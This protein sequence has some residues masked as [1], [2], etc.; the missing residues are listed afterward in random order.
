MAVTKSRPSK[1]TPPTIKL[2]TSAIQSFGGMAGSPTQKPLGKGADPAFAFKPYQTPKEAPFG[3]YDPQLFTQGQT[4]GANL[5]FADADTGLANVRAQEDLWHALGQAA[6]QHDWT[7]SDLSLQDARNRQN[8]ETQTQDLTRQYDRLGTSQTQ[9]ANAAGVGSGGALVAAA[10]A[11]QGNQALDQS[12]LQTAFDRESQDVA[13]RKMRENQAYNQGLADLQT[14]YQRGYS[15]RTT[16]Q[17]RRDWMYATIYQPGLTR[18]EVSNAQ[19]AGML[20]TPPVNEH[21]NPDTG[22]GDYRTVVNTHKGIVYHVHPNGQKIVVRHV[23]PTAPPPTP[24]PK[25]K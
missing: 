24:K 19:Q 23:T 4:Q 3:S 11:R 5:L 9:A 21:I 6:Q 20:P 12:R 14:N 18:A 16:D 17:A 15:D 1:K 10:A 2:P 22:V 7:Q 8:F 25:A 13:T